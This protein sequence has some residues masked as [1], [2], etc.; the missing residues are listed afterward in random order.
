MSRV[1]PPRTLRGR[2][3]LLGGLSLLYLVAVTVQLGSVLLPAVAA[4]EGRA[5]DLVADHDRIPCRPRATR[6]AGG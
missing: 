2:L 4:I 6:A 1:H 3:A 5:R